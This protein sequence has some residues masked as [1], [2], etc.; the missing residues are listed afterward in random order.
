MPWPIQFSQVY[1]IHSTR[2]VSF[3]WQDGKNKKYPYIPKKT[4][5]IHQGWNVISVGFTWG[6]QNLTSS[7]LCKS[8]PF[9]LTLPCGK[10]PS[11]TN[12]NALAQECGRLL[13]TTR[14]CILT[15]II[16]SDDRHCGFERPRHPCPIPCGPRQNKSR[17]PLPLGELRFLTEHLIKLREAPPDWPEVIRHVP[18]PNPSGPLHQTRPIFPIRLITIRRFAWRTRWWQTNKLGFHLAIQTPQN[19]ETAILKSA[20]P[21]P[22]RFKLKKH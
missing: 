13:Y 12:E 16:R 14:T 10:A 17:D 9:Y 8:S 7:M 1:G 3:G 11:W 2:T 20:Y 6:G 5:S 15:V 21:T 19:S 22:S 4:K 18:R